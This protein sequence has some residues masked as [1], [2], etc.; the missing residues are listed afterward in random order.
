MA[1]FVNGHFE[2]RIGAGVSHLERSSSD[3]ELK[4]L[5]IDD[6]YDGGDQV[7]DKLGPKR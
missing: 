6:V 4:E 2:R 1:V 3:V 7:L 5:L